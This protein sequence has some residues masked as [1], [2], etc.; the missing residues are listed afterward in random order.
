MTA[1]NKRAPN[2]RDLTDRFIRG[3]KPP[4]KKIIYWDTKKGAAQSSGMC[5]I[6]QPTGHLS[7]KVAYRSGGLLRWYT[8]GS[9]GK[10]FLKE[11][12]EVARE[13][14]KRVALACFKS[15]T[16]CPGSRRTW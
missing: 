7:F 6:A 10:V 16:F 15:R 12:R 8:I 2:R 1:L 4:P 5:L 14:N 13:I 11:A 9:Y 3:L